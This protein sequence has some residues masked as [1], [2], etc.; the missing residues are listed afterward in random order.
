[1]INRIT[2][3]NLCLGCGLCASICPSIKMEEDK[4]G[5]YIPTSS[6][7]SD[8]ENLLLR[9]ACP[10]LT[11][12]AEQQKGDWGN[13]V[14]SY[15]AWSTNADI[16]FRAASGGAVTAIALFL[17]EHH[18]VD[19]IMQVGVCDGDYLH[20]TMKISRCSQDIISN[21]QSRYAPCLTLNNIQQILASTKDTFAF[22]GKPCD[23]AGIKN[24]LSIFP[25]YKKR[26]SCFIS[27]FC[28]AMPSYNASIKAWKCSGKSDA[29]QKI[30]YRGD[31]WPGQFC[32]QWADRSQFTLSYDD[33]WGKILGRDVA[34]RCK[35][36]PDGIGLLADISVGDAWRIKNKQPDFTEQPG[37]SV[38]LARTEIGQ[39]IVQDAISHHYLDAES[40]DIDS[41]K[42]RQ[43]YQ[44]IRRRQLGWRLLPVQLKTRWLLDFKGLQVRELALRANPFM[45]CKMFF[46]MIKR[47]RKK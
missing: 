6:T 12:H 18:L 34:F 9:Q 15:D 27:I 26:F 29:P 24:Y 35:I 38:V 33:S 14:Q 25:Q 1:M 13:I 43:P 23:I 39:T 44:Y 31:G 46:G 40:F 47:M 36:C 19:A 21:C 4:R 8:E 20:N 41:L 16:R 42:F 2:S 30:T 10:A 3:N 32:A 45:A 28:A 22:I 17:L 7:L 11:I 37:H 5:F